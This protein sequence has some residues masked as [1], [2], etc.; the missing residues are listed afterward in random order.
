[1]I[2]AGATIAA[3]VILGTAVR[4]SAPPQLPQRTVDAP[5]PT[6]GQGAVVRTPNDPAQWVP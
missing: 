4:D 5:I 2:L 1:V 6:V 3:A